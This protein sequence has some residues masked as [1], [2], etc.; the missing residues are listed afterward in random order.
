MPL[1]VPP[2]PAPARF[3]FGV[4]HAT[5][6]AGIVPQGWEVPDHHGLPLSAVQ[7]FQAF[8]DC[9]PPPIP[10]VCQQRRHRV[11]AC[12]VGGCA[13]WLRGG[14][15]LGKRRCGGRRAYISPKTPHEIRPFFDGTQMS[16]VNEGE[17]T[18]RLWSGRGKP[19]PGLG[20]EG[21][22]GYTRVRVAKI[23]RAASEKSSDGRARDGVCLHKH[24][25]P[26]EGGVNHPK[27]SRFGGRYCQSNAHFG[28]SLR[29]R[30]S[31]LWTAECC[32]CSP[33]RGG[34]GISV[35]LLTTAAIAHFRP[36]PGFTFGLC[37]TGNL[38][39]APHHS[40]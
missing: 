15:A 24:V 9:P 8:C 16:P 29:R 26:V 20:G 31:G 30:T 39:G 17:K 12:G 32:P 4:F 37:Q 25:W 10:A 11:C 14:R 27:Q 19:G 5:T 21:K 33:C 35:P 23:V 34:S 38:E 22:R 2:M 28:C 7:H 18:W 40:M 6:N 13:G 3:T 36:H 1:S